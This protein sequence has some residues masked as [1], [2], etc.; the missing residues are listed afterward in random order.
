MQ[1]RLI[2]AVIALFVSISVAQAQEP[3]I[4]GEIRRIDEAAG[5][6]SIRH[7]PIKKF[8]MDEDDMTMVFHVQDP[9]MLKQVKVGDKVQFDAEHQAAGF[10]ITK[11]EKSK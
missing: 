5:K 7:G 11:M 1:S 8:D 3:L 10:T 2:P 9:V 6:I 4:K